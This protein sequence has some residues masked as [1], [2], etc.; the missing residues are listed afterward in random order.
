MNYISDNIV[1]TLKKI[2]K[3]DKPT[4]FIYT[5][6]HGE[7]PLTGRAHD[8]SRYIWEMSSVPFLIYFNEEAKLKY[9]DLFTR[10]NSRAL[11]KNRDSLNNFPSLIL[12]IFGI[13]IFNKDSKLNDV[14]VCKFGIG[15]CFVDYHI[16][17]NQINT[18]G[19]VRLNYPVKD[20]NTLTDNTDRPTTFSNMKHYLL[21][22]GSDLEICSHRTNS[23]ARFIRFNAILNCMEIDVI[24]NEDYLDVSHSKK[25]STSLK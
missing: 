3:I 2:S 22:K 15:N 24:I 10:I 19:V 9:P 13:E 25:I 17:R 16:I 20:N 18:F 1:F 14:S 8:S 12:E 6:D 7:S 5:A 11:Q 21:K 23:I 4:I